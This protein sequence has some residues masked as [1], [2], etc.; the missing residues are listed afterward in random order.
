MNLKVKLWHQEVIS[1][2]PNELRLLDLPRSSGGSY[3]ASEMR[4]LDQQA[5]KPV[6]GAP[7]PE[8]PQG[9]ASAFADWRTDVTFSIG[10][11]DG[12][13]FAAA[14]TDSYGQAM[15]CRVTPRGEIIDADLGAPSL[16]PWRWSLTND[17]VLAPIDPA[18]REGDSWVR[19]TMIPLPQAQLRQAPAL[20]QTSGKFRFEGREDC[21]GKRC[22]V[23]SK[24]ENLEPGSLQPQDL[25]DPEYADY[26]GQRN[27]HLTS[28]GE[29]VYVKA[30]IDE[31]TGLPVRTELRSTGAFWWE[32]TDQP[33]S[34]ISSH[35][36]KRVYEDGKATRHVV[37]IGR[38]MTA[39]FERAA[40]SKPDAGSR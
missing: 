6:P 27:I 40:A 3:V 37:T 35:D 22:F 13:A 19:K 8:K 18:A 28:E 30:W 15:N 32:D 25:I 10:K 14:W 16:A 11:F 38:L 26:F 12:S 9:F 2:Y 33:D 5:A 4:A 1:G 34:F 20:R 23:Y 31:Q 17:V 24:T 36:S 29:M 21:A 39:T 7:K